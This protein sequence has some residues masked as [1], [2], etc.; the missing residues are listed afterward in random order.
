[1]GLVEATI[2]LHFEVRHE[3]EGR[4]RFYCETLR[5]EPK[6]ARKV[7][8]RLSLVPGIKS[9]RVN[10]W[11]AGLIVAYADAVIGKEAVL[12]LVANLTLTTEE[13]SFELA[14]PSQRMLPARRLSEVLLPAI[15]FLERIFP[16]VVQL[17]I[18]AVAFASAFLRAPVMVTRLL[19]S[20]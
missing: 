6:I 15:S 9:V 17:G 2:S 13:L 20:L 16:A 19:L 18:G 8:E 1:I 5:D 14:V 12:L 7:T 10:T 11:C 3:V 4:L